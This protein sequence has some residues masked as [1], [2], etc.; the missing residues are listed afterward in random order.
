MVIWKVPR[1]FFVW[2]FLHMNVA[3][4]TILVITCTVSSN[5]VSVRA[6]FLWWILCWYQLSCSTN[7]LWGH[8]SNI[9]CPIN[10]TVRPSSHSRYIALNFVQLSLMSPAQYSCLFQPSPYYVHM[11][12]WIAAVGLSHL[13]HSWISSRLLHV[14]GISYSHFFTILVSKVSNFVCFRIQAIIMLIFPSPYC[15]VFNFMNV[16]ISMSF[17]SSGAHCSNLLSTLPTK[18]VNVFVFWFF[19]SFPQNFTIVYS[20]FVLFP[21]VFV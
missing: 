19:L 2:T 18:H 3:S 14:F 5:F 9:L 16:S 4:L 21:I 13:Q 8:V 20:P 1:S 17:S 15:A 6:W 10:Y 11:F 12:Y 7:M